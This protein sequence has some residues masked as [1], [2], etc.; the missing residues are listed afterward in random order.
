MPD[1]KVYIHDAYLISVGPGGLSVQ[2]YIQCI[3]LSGILA[4]LKVNDCTLFFAAVD[5]KKQ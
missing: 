4:V 2:Y 5:H 3:V 1:F